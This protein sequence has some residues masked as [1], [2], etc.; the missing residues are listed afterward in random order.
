MLS[1]LSLLMPFLAIAVW[2]SGLIIRAK[3]FDEVPIGGI[4]VLL[5]SMS[6]FFF[7][8]G[9]FKIKWNNFQFKIINGVCIGLAFSLFTA[10]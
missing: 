8:F 6:L 10:Y 5:V 1:W 9:V 2:A 3:D 7:V 4:C